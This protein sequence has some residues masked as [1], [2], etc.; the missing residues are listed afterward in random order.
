MTT[1]SAPPGPGMRVLLISPWIKL[2][3]SECL[4]LRLA[5]LLSARGCQV[6]VACCFVDS[7]LI[8]D[9]VA[10]VH[11]IQ[12]WRW[13]GALSRRHRALLSLLGC[14]ALLVS[15]LRRA[16]SYELLNPHNFPSLWIAACVAKLSGAR[17]VWHFN[18]AAP[19]PGALNVLERT[20]ARQAGAITV[21]DQQSG[22]Q[23]QH[24]FGRES[25]LV[26]PGVDFAN[27]SQPS[28]RDDAAGPA[29][30]LT[31]GKLHAQKNQIV[32]I[33]AVHALA[34]DLPGLR[35]IITGE[36]PDRQRLE[37]RVDDL[38]LRERVWFSGLVDAS[39]LRVFYR[40]AFLVCFPALRQTWGLTPFEALC[41]K[42]VSLVSSQAGAAEVIAAEGI[43]LVAEPN[44]QSFAGAIR[45]AFAAPD[46]MRQM[47]ERGF[48][49]VRDVMSWERFGDRML[50]VLRNDTSDVASAA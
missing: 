27:W 7:R 8:E 21:L 33:E 28:A 1:S 16:R 42:T 40:S 31:V 30:L 19:I 5:R 2:G 46:V 11:F 9:E 34:D 38:R 44:L 15:V 25:T 49:F 23:V 50:E 36:G 48:A 13:I 39:T 26:R 45:Q 10:G 22:A 35:L 3:G 20:A 12:P 37:Q 17:I 14:P 24:A 18:E 41:Q 6:S 29:M 43:G 47:G 32:L 4:V